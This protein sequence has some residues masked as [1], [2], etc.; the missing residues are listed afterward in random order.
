MADNGV[1]SI[2]EEG[3]SAETGP[4]VKWTYSQDKCMLTIASGYG[5]ETYK[6]G[7]TWKGFDWTLVDTGLQT[8]ESGNLVGEV[9]S[10]KTRKS[11]KSTTLQFPLSVSISIDELLTMLR[12][13]H[14]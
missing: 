12:K 3:R 8:E 11:K 10:I 5:N 14:H 2:V 4:I 6:V 9:E 7:R 1:W 13:V